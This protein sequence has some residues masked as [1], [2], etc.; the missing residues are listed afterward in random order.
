MVLECLKKFLYEYRVDRDFSKEIKDGYRNPLEKDLNFYFEDKPNY[1]YGGSLAK[2]T[3]NSN[4]CDIDL[5]C[6]FDSDNKDSLET[7]FNNTLK[8]L[9]KASYLVEP[10][11]SAICVKGKIGE[12]KWDTTVDVVPG[13]YTSNDDNKDV[14]LWCRKDRCRLKSNPELQ[15]N[16]VLKSDCKDLVRIL[17]LYRSFNNFKFKSFYLEIFAIDIVQPEFRDDDNLYDKLVK[18]CSHY[19]DIGKL[20]IY[21]PANSANDINSI[22]TDYEFDIIRN[23]IKELYMA[24]LTNDENTVYCCLKNKPYDVDNGYI[25]DAKS[26]FINKEGLSKTLNPYFNVIT[27]SGFYYMNGSWI[28][29]DS[30]TVLKKNYNLK[31][32]ISVAPSFQQG[33]TVR[34][35]VSNGGYEALK[36]NCLRGKS[37]ETEI[38]YKANNK[39]YY[40]YETTSYYG[41]HCVQAYVKTSSGKT[42]YSDV[43]VVKVR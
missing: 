34:L 4:S 43:L 19:A 24:L 18:F 21:D 27:I 25:N 3:A 35:I 6:Y 33:S 42:Y 22:H 10:K 31:F 12:D 7:I 26:H 28:R 23:K 14:Y 32:D 16:K 1:R 15:I 8:A 37:E 39:Y 36:H 13:K 9:T 38:H 30:N 20:K 17:K 5:L 11:N 2:M 29:F 40:R 41:N